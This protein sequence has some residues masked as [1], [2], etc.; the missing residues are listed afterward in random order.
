VVPARAG[1]YAAFV[2]VCVRVCV[3]YALVVPARAGGYAAQAAHNV[4][5][6]PFKLQH[7]V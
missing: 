1:G 6:R 2:C 4:E 5:H 7:L 3:Y